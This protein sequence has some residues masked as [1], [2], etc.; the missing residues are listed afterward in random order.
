MPIEGRR[1]AQNKSF[2][3]LFKGGGGPG[4]K[5]LWSRSAEREIFPAAPEKSIVKLHAR[6][7]LSDFAARGGKQRR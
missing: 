1:E 7:G 5:A 2:V 6:R 3:H 4:G